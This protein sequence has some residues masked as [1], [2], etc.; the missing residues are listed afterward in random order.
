MT[1][2]C[3]LLLKGIVIGEK[4][5]DFPFR[6]LKILFYYLPSSIISC[7]KSVI[8]LIEVPLNVMCCFFPSVPFNIYMYTFIFLFYFIFILDAWG[9]CTEMTQWDGTGRE[10][11][12]GF[13]MGNM[14]IPVADS[15]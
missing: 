14:C 13:R 8:I 3:F 6:I 15:C 7:E 9:W 12:V 5:R 10:K 1:L 11:G 2:V 4:L